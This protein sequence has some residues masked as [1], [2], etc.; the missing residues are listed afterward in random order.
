MRKRL[1]LS[2]A[3]VFSALPLAKSVFRFQCAVNRHHVVFVKSANYLHVF[4]CGGT[5]SVGG[6][7][8]CRAGGHWF[9][10][11][12]RTNTQGLQDFISQSLLVKV[13]EGNEGAPS[14]LQ[15]ARPSCGS[16]DHIK[17][18]SHLQLET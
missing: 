6:A 17:W 16:D 8:D 4:G 15:A 11:R 14:A 7:L 1:N 12:N 10:F 18:R 9:D 2:F 3:F 5:S 13:T